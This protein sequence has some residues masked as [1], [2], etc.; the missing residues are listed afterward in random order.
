MGVSCQHLSKQHKLQKLV[1][2]MM[3][4]IILTLK[5]L[6]LLNLLLCCQCSRI[7]PGLVMLISAPSSVHNIKCY[8]DTQGIPIEDAPVIIAE[9]KEFDCALGGGKQKNC[10]KETKDV[11][12]HRMTFRNCGSVDE[13][14]GC[15]T[16]IANVTRCYCAQD[17]C[18]SGHHHVLS[19]A[20]IFL[21]MLFFNL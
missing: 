3:R 4:M 15:S 10:L 20:L 19:S 12:G 1:K 14:T 13:K 16:D 6:L 17:Y 2:V 18:N 21:S 5:T 7:V 9:F 11:D 8:I